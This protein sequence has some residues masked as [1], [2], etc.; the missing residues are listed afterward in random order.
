MCEDDS[1]EINDVVQHICGNPSATKELD[2]VLAEAESHGCQ[3]LLEG[4]WVNDTS[5][6]SERAQFLQDQLINSEYTCILCMDLHAHTYFICSYMYGQT[7]DGKSMEY[8]YFSH[9]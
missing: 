7:K 1:L 4:I 9:W 8:G 2:S 3:D 6:L 5:N